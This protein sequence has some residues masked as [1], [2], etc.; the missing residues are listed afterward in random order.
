MAKLQNRGKKVKSLLKVALALLVV[1]VMLSGTS[2]NLLAA[3]QYELQSQAHNTFF[4]PAAMDIA[5]IEPFDNRPMLRHW[6]ASPNLIIVPMGQNYFDVTLRTEWTPFNFFPDMNTS[7][8]VSII[9]PYRALSLVPSSILVK[10]E[11]HSRVR[12]DH[13]HNF[14]PGSFPIEAGFPPEGQ[15]SHGFIASSA[16]PGSFLNAPPWDRGAFTFRVTINPEFLQNPGDIMSVRVHRHASS[17]SGAYR[18]GISYLTII[19]GG[20]NPPCPDTN[21]AHNSLGA[22]MTASSEHPQRRAI[23][24]N[25]GVRSGLPATAWIASGVDNE[26]LM[27]DFG[28]IRSFNTVRIYQ[29]GMRISDYRFE[30]SVDGSSWNSLHQGSRMLVESPNHYEVRAENTIHARFVRLYSGRSNHPTT[31]IAIFEFEVYYLP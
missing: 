10:Y 30:Y 16:Y 28:Q 17:V 14:P 7:D 26:W 4:E 3:P 12:F 21:L 11:A 8:M 19:R 6:E 29:A 2:I 13:S 22:V 23:L 18:P 24:T 27:V 5:G 20:F 31:P 25:N 15:S 1:T 9:F